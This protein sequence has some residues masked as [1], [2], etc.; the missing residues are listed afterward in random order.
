MYLDGMTYSEI[1]LK[2]RHSV[3]AIKR[4]LE[5]FTKVIMAERRGIYRNKEIS[6]VTGLSETIVKQYRELLRESKKDRIRKENLKMLIERSSYRE[7]IKKR[8]E[9]A[10]KPVAAM[11]GGL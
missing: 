4:Y 10:S 2:A 11:M 6:I 1:K 9:K 5:S 3:G 7:G 8:L